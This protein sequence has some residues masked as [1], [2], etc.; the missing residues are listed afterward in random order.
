MKRRNIIILV[1][2]VIAGIG[3]YIGYTKIKESTTDHSNRKADH[4]ITASE[5]I[6]AFD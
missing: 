6:A 5:L 3:A 1:I 4:F 2:L